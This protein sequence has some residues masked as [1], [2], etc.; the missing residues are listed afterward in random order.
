MIVKSAKKF[1][2]P[3]RRLIFGI[4]FFDLMQSLAIFL[5][6]WKT[7]P[8]QPNAWISLGNQTSCNFLGWVYLAGLNSGLL[9]ILSLNIYY[10][11][12]VRYNLTAHHYRTSAK[13]FLHAIPIGW[14]IITSTTILVTG[15]YNPAYPGECFIAPY[16]INCLLNPDV[17]TC[18]RGERT[19]TFRLWFHVIPIMFAFIFCLYNRG[20]RN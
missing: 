12:L 16:P 1:T 13:P 17:L 18:I 19:N 6:I 20:P 15:H 9:Y 4:S 8:E 10:L 7:T 14:A 3:Y 2:D 5:K 11:C